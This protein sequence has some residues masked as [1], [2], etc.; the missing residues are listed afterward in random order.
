MPGSSAPPITNRT[1]H[2]NIARV[3]AQGQGEM[4]ALA[5]MLAPAEVDAVAKYVVKSLG[6]KERTRGAPPS[7]D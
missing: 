2:A 7:D 5:A 3:I 6:P 4:P 1:D